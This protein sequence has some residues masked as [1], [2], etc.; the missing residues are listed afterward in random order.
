MATSG[1]ATWNPDYGQIVE[2]AYNLASGGKSIR[3]G[4][5]L[6][7]ARFGLNNL[8]AEW[9][10][11]GLNLWTVEEGTLALTQ[12]TGTYAL[13]AD[14]VDIIEYVIREGSGDTQSDIKI[15]RISMPTYAAIP[16]KT[17]QSM[18]TQIYV[19]RTLTP[20]VK[21][22]PIPD[23]SYTLVYWRIRRIEDAGNRVDFTLDIPP[24]F[25]PALIT[26]LAHWIAMNKAEFTERVPYLEGQYNK[27]WALAAGEDRERASWQIMPWNYMPR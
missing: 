16:N 2:Q 8:F 27:Q 14:T 19:E 1:S 3:G 24:R 5:D 17:T 6:N 26:G 15:T 22:W 9:A 23:Q 25:L 13:P 10:N 20:Q 7:M 12:G 21:L 4:Y 11:Q 18:P